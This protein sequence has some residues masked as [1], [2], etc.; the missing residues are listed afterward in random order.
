MLTV[1]P[2]IPH[3]DQSKVVRQSAGFTQRDLLCDGVVLA[4]AHPR[5]EGGKRCRPDVVDA[6]LRQVGHRLDAQVDGAIDL[7][8]SRASLTS[9]ALLDDLQKCPRRRWTVIFVGPT[10]GERLL[11]RTNMGLKLCPLYS[12]LGGTIVIRRAEWLRKHRRARLALIY[13]A[14]WDRREPRKANAREWER[15]LGRA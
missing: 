8:D 2:D 9:A 4:I 12:S 5:R 10:H 6:V 15:I 7:A 13:F 3:D 11:V 14:R 1:A